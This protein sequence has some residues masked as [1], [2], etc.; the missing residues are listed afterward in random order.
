M[1]LIY[2]TKYGCSLCDEGLQMLRHLPSI[3][4][5]IID[6]EDDLVKYQSYLTRIPV[7][8]TSDGQR[9]VSWPFTIEDI[10]TL[11]NEQ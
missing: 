3:D 11:L 1:K 7:V 2:Y 6:I 9:E 4:L 5:T 8:A 10:Q